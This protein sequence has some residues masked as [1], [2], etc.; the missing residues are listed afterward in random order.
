V[1][2]LFDEEEEVEENVAGEYLR[3]RR[4]VDVDMAGIKMDREENGVE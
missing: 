1:D 3:C 4:D 2:D